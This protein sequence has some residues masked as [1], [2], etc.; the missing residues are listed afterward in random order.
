[1]SAPDL[2]LSDPGSLAIAAATTLL[3]FPSFIF[4]EL[5]EGP[6]GTLAV[7]AIP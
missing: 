4:L 5:L 6:P 7:A 1:M 2:N 3:F